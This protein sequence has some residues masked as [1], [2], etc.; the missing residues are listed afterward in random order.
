MLNFQKME[1]YIQAKQKI[2]PRS[3]LFIGFFIISI[4][5]WFS[6]D[7]LARHLA[8]GKETQKQQATPQTASV[9]GA[10]DFKK[11]VNRVYLENLFPVEDRIPLRQ[12]EM[13]ELVLPNA[14]ASLILDAQSGVIL[15]HKGGTTHRQIAS[16][17]K[18]MTA[19][20]VMEN[21]DSLEEVVTITDDVYGIEGTVVGCPRTGYCTSNKLVEG[22]QLTVRDLM[23]A[24]LMNSTNDAALAL[25]IYIS[26]SEQK[27]VD[28]M[29]SQVREWGFQDTHFCTPSGLEIDG[30]ESSCYSTAYDIARIAAKLLQYEDVWKIMQTPAMTIYSVDG[31][32]SHEILNTDQ[33]LGSANIMGA[34]TGFTPAAGRSLLAVGHDGKGNNPVVAVLLDDPYRWEDIKEMFSW[35]YSAYRWE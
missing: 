3:L 29:N 14:H 26:G 16:L 25:G 35:A 27:F 28:K 8:E 1:N 32:R 21:V 11:E 4:A 5:F 33:I 34:K 6:G 31:K 30:Q 2:F 20:L 19:L 10:Q 24:M 17:T 23:R 15:H 7:M 18:V 9:Q 12:M 22:E 13:A